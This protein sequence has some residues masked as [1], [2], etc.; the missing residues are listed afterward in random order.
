MVATVD[1]GTPMPVFSGSQM[2]EALAAW[3][4]L[5]QALDR[6]MPDQILRIGDRYFRKK[7]YWKAVSTAFKL[8]VEMVEERQEIQ[9]QFQDG[10]NNVG[11]FVTYRAQ[12]PNGRV[13]TGD[14][15][16][17]AVEKAGRYKCPHPHPTQVGKSAHYPAS[18]CPDY[19]PEY[20]WQSYP[21]EG[22]I[23]NIRAH[24]HTR[25]ANRAIS[26]LVGFGEVTAE[27]LNPEE[28]SQAIAV[29]PPQ[30]QPDP[31]EPPEP[32][33]YDGEEPESRPAPRPAP[34]PYSHGGGGGGSRQGGVISEPQAKRLWA[35]AKGAGWS[36][37]GIEKYLRSLG[38][39]HS[40]EVTRRMYE[41]VIHELETQSPR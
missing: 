7:Q 28:E 16:C 39:N 34:R 40:R 2:S 18:T 14:G 13:C 37:Q 27:E 21:A 22:S 5:Q 30:A 19:S 6:S 23:H 33:F 12:A 41:Q 8:N 17:F 15:C 35:I 10:S 4:G 32:G 38:F 9:G 1:D 11:F 36:N 29:I 24:A 20:V 31:A 25:A 3:K 26:N